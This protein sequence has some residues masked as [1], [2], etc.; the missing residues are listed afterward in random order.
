[1]LGLNFSGRSFKVVLYTR[2]ELGVTIYISE[3]VNKVF[4]LSGCKVVLHHHLVEVL[5]KVLVLISLLN[6]RDLINLALL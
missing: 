2:W 6:F 4:E 1:L 3:D 5:S